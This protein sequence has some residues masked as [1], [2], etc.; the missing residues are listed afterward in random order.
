MLSLDTCGRL[1]STRCL[2]VGTA[3]IPA[4]HTTRHRLKVTSVAGSMGLPGRRRHQHRARCCDSKYLLTQGAGLECTS[5]P[6][7]ARNVE[8]LAPPSPRANSPGR[9]KLRLHEQSGLYASEEKRNTSQSFP[10]TQGSR[11][12]QVHNATNR[13]LQKMATKATQPHH[14]RLKQA[15][16]EDRS[17]A[18]LGSL[19]PGQP[20][21][22]WLQAGSPPH[23]G[24]RVGVEGCLSASRE[25][26]KPS[27]ETTAFNPWH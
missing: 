16:Q 20:F 11:T 7:N 2:F 4:S 12:G 27:R 6:S 3:V 26:L 10:A 22:S 25:L 17:F 5:A 15:M 24:F 13:S 14:S 1:G 18:S 9:T 23:A 8:G 19:E 21:Q